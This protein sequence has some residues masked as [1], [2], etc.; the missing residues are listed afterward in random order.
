MS[1][2]GA[3]WPCIRKYY[4]GSMVS[5]RSSLITSQRANGEI[6]TRRVQ[7]TNKRLST[8]FCSRQYGAN[9]TGGYI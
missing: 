1:L 8:V 7:F 3:D 4:T 2:G 6:Y 5:N 9:S